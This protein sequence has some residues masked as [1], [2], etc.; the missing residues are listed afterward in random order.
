[1]ALNQFKCRR[2]GRNPTEHECK[3]ITS[4][5]SGTKPAVRISTPV[6]LISSADWVTG[7]IDGDMNDFD[8]SSINQVSDVSAI[9]KH[10]H[11]IPNF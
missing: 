5:V 7:V 6:G 4:S 9:Y 11:F 1:M 10:L 3:L 8:W 2:A